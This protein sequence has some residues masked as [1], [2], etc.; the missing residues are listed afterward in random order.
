MVGDLH[1]ACVVQDMIFC[2]DDRHAEGGE[3]LERE[4]GA[5]PGQAEKAARAVKKAAAG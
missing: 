3:W 2:E 1:E 5:V 4:L